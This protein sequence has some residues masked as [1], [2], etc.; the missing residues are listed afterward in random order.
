MKSVSS[1]YTQSSSY[2]PRTRPP[3]LLAA[4]TGTVQWLCRTTEYGVT[5]NAKL[6]LFGIMIAV[7]GSPQARGLLWCR[8]AGLLDRLMV[9]RFPDLFATCHVVSEL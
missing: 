8:R 7:P 1:V 6:G 3:T 2:H 5:L 4:A 9:P